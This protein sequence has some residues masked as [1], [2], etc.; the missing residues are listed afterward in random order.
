MKP[1]RLS[2]FA[3]GYQ[4]KNGRNRFGRLCIAKPLPHVDARLI[5]QDWQP[6]LDR[7]VFGTVFVGSFYLTQASRTSIQI[8]P[9]PEL[10]FLEGLFLTQIRPRGVTLVALVRHGV[11]GV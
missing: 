6:S 3:V 9:V 1:R 4:A 5:L 11:A 2:T 10:I 7:H 8:V